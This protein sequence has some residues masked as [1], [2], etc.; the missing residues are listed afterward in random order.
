[1]L[2]PVLFNIF[3]D[4]GTERTLSKFEDN[5]TVGGVVGLLVTNKLNELAMRPYD[6]EGHHPGPQKQKH[7]QQVEGGDSSLLLTAGEKLL[8]CWVP[9]WVAQ[10]KRHGRAGV[11]PTKGQDGDDGIGA[12]ETQEA[13]ERTSATQL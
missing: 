8:Q 7:C 10:H 1:M 12:S 6:K 5:K 13:A 11:T 3:L 2:A 9:F 4:A